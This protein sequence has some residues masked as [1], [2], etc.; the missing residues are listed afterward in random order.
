MNDFAWRKSPL[1]SFKGLGQH[2]NRFADDNTSDH[3]TVSAP[4][5]NHLGILGVV[6][7]LVTAAWRDL[8][9]DSETLHHDEGVNGLFLLRLFRE[10][11]P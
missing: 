4:P 7:V 5:T 3:H 9:V 10:G 6:T 1:T 8:C 11:T 2:L